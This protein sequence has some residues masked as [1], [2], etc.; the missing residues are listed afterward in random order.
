MAAFKDLRATASPQ[1]GDDRKIAALKIETSKAIEAGKLAEADA[2]LAR[3]EAEQTR[4]LDRQAVDAAATRARRG[5]IAL[6]R[7]AMP[8]PPSTSPT[9]PW[10]FRLEFL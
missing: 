8:K 9:L 3:I 2:L 6:T 4:A 1:P 7:C 5:E 10:C